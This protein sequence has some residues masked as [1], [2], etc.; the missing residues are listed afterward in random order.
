LNEKESNMRE[1]LSLDEKTKIEASNDHEER[2][3]SRYLKM[4]GIC[5][6]D[7]DDNP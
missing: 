7:L 1:K 4:P 6:K 5:L 3:E 2:Y